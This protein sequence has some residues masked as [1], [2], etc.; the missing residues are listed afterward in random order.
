MNS[1]QAEHNK[2][3]DYVYKV[4][5]QTLRETAQ[6]EEVA[7]DE[8][9]DLV[10][11]GRVTPGLARRVDEVVVEHVVEQVF[12]WR[13]RPRESGGEAGRSAR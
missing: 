7:L 6:K 1:L 9:A 11:L 4:A 12:C 5:T 13:A 2:K 3:H 10:T 8:V